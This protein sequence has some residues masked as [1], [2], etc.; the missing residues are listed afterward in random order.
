[1]VLLILRF[2]KNCVALGLKELSSKRV[3][4]LANADAGTAFI[5]FLS[6][7]EE[8]KK[9]EHASENVS[10]N[11]FPLSVAHSPRFS[12]AAITDLLTDFYRGVGVS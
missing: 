7:L 6:A 4:V 11:Q 3:D 8:K 5:T 9:E 10:F 12:S 2:I 1:M